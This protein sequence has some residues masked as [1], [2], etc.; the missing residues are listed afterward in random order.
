MATVKVDGSEIKNAK[1]GDRIVCHGEGNDEFIVST[2]GS[3]KLFVSTKYGFAYTRLQLIAK[4][5]RVT[6]EMELM[7]CK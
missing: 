6:D 1:V 3:F 5:S 7:P 2:F 4:Y